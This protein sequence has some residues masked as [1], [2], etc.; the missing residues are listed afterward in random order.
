MAPLGAG[1]TKDCLV[2]VGEYTVF[3]YANIAE[4]KKFEYTSVIK[5]K[6]KV[7]IVNF[8]SKNGKRQNI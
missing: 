7:K 2:N 4:K 1:C 5:V 6:V 8:V 3:R